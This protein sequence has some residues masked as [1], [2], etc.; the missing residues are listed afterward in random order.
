MKK[1]SVIYLLVLVFFAFAQSISAQQIIF[2]L[3]GINGSTNVGSASN[4]YAI[5]YASD[6]VTLS[7]YVKASESNTCVGTYFEVTDNIDMSG[8][9]NFVPIGGRN[10]RN[11]YAKRN[12]FKGNFDGSEFVISNLK[13]ESDQTCTGLFGYTQDAMLIDIV[14]YNANIKGTGVVGALAGDITSSDSTAVSRCRGN[15]I[16]DS[17]IEGT[18]GCIGGLVG[19]LKQSGMDS[20]FVRNTKIIANNTTNAIYVGSLVGQVSNTVAQTIEYCYAV[21]DT[22]TGGTYIGGLVGGCSANGTLLNISWSYAVVEINSTNPVATA[23]GI[24]ATSNYNVNVVYVNDSWQGSGTFASI[25]IATWTD[26]PDSYFFVDGDQTGYATLFGALNTSS[27]FASDNEISG[28]QINYG[29]PVL[30]SELPIYII[31]TPS[32]LQS[33]SSYVRTAEDNN[34]YGFMFLQ[35]NDIDMSA[36]PTF[37]PIGGRTDNGYSYTDSRYF[38]GMYDGLGHTIKKLTI[39][40]SRGGDYHT[41]FFGLAKNGA[42]IQN[43]TLDSCNITGRNYT[44]AL[45]G[46]LRVDNN[47]YPNKIKNCH[48]RNTKV[49]QFAANDRLGGMIGYSYNSTAETTNPSTLDSCSVKFVN[50]MPYG[51]S[52]R[53]GGLIG[54]IERGL[55]ITNCYTEHSTI[56][57]STTTNKAG[58]Y[59]GGVIGQYSGGSNQSSRRIIDN[60]HSSH[61]IVR[62]DGDY[63]GGMIGRLD[64]YTDITNCYSTY[65][66]V[67]TDANWVGGLTGW[68]DN[69]VEVYRCF[70]VYC[71]VYGGH[72]AG[73]LIGDK[74]DTPN[75]TVIE[76]YSLYC[77]VRGTDYVG[78]LVGGT[79][80]QS[81]VR[82]CYSS[83]C[84]ITSTSSYVG[85]L[86]GYADVTDFVN[87]YTTNTI[88]ST[89]ATSQKGGLS[90]Y[91]AN[92]TD[93]TNSYYIDTW[94]EG[95]SV[96]NQAD[97]AKRGTALPSSQMKDMMSFVDTLNA[98]RAETVWYLDT[99]LYVNGGYPILAHSRGVPGATYQI[100]TPDDL[101]ELSSMVQ[102]GFQT[103]EVNFTLM[104]NIIFSTQDNTTNPMV[105]IGGWADANTNDTTKAFSGNFVGNKFHF[106]NINITKNAQSH[107]YVGIF[108]LVKGGRIEEVALISSNMSGRDYVGGL[109]GKL[110]STAVLTEA[111]ATGDIVGNAYIGGLIGAST[112]LTNVSACY[113]RSN[114]EGVSNVGGLIG[115]SGNLSNSYSVSNVNIAPTTSTIDTSTFGGLVG[116]TTNAASIH[117]SYYS[118]TWTDNPSIS[119]NAFGVP[120]PKTDM[121]YKQPFIDSLNRGLTFNAWSMDN[122]PWFRNGGYPILGYEPSASEL[123]IIESGVTVKVS[124][125]NDYNT[126]PRRIIIRDGGSFVNAITSKPAFTNVNV[127]HK[128]FN[129]RYAFVG[130]TFGTLKVK[131][132]LGIPDSNHSLYNNIRNGSAVSM[133]QFNY[134]TNKWSGDPGTPTYLGYN[135]DMVPAHG[136]FA[137]VLDPTYDPTLPNNGL[138]DSVGTS[139]NLSM[140]TPS[141]SKLFSQDTAIT[142]I[143]TG[144]LLTDE[145]PNIP[146]LWY[147]ISNP[148]PGNLY[149]YIFGNGGSSYNG[150]NTELKSNY[151]YRLSD[152][153]TWQAVPTDVNSREHFVKMGEGFFVAGK[154]DLTTPSH[155]F[156]FKSS[157]TDG[158]SLAAKKSLHKPQSIVVKV[159]TERDYR[160]SQQAQININSNSSNGFDEKDAFKLRG[161]NEKICEPFFVI[162]S[163]NLAVNT[164][165]TLPYACDM[166]ISSADVKYVTIM[167]S[168]PDN[169]TAQFIDQSDT[170]NIG[171]RFEYNAILSRGDNSN[172]FKIL[173]DGK[174]SLNSVLQEALDVWIYD[175]VLK[176]NGRD[177]K[178]LQIVNSLGQIVYSKTLSGDAFETNLNLPK[179]NYIAK[180]TSSTGSK[181]I[182]FVMVR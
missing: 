27:K 99:S 166:N 134:L 179:G 165:S 55:N 21:K 60:C 31:K 38:R 7:D 23:G 39:N 32:D 143:N 137:Y 58:S 108:G 98:G 120:T 16:I 127:E 22:L 122:Q 52:D 110:D 125:T 34:G 149:A 66:S 40:D 109:V 139:I 13:I 107:D 53:V 177:L 133:L 147:A 140:A 154:G 79:T 124:T 83:L 138:T 65:D 90:G 37:I 28:L 95:S 164:I 74:G 12:A 159:V 75:S 102:N 70:A 62:G 14:L 152:N 158:S 87:C 91:S 49:L 71:Q 161:H 76:C 146:A 36:I 81:L 51:S 181:T 174:S 93:V 167:I 1:K 128:L 73:G 63:T 113:S 178:N 94:W 69:Y 103:A 135:S 6:L 78:G 131:N 43:I 176:I 57:M 141:G 136:Y 129:E 5:R 30:K 88:D 47:A 157:M 56:G 182:K 169:I 20:S 121:I 117:H 130:S 168:V 123:V 35:V 89:L 100:W 15:A 111:F 86:I 80:N 132:Y 3:S 162:D 155:T 8:I 175:N 29:C 44:G 50:V 68:N 163:S 2:G 116:S 46:Y 24:I 10:S 144:R 85:G 142:I 72:D 45:I 170:L 105:P 84:E 26:F 118:Q 17:R 67:Y 156:T 104:D 119:N 4:P 171:N 33:L 148:Y 106:E 64:N 97:N 151:I 19:N 59:V 18:D 96:P 153:G 42:S 145:E 92:A 54:E 180:A 160:L 173:I 150:N 25:Y 126:R 172:R 77:S 48:V 41:G 11:R 82:D 101:K 61:N 114:V 112:A 9:E 115:Q